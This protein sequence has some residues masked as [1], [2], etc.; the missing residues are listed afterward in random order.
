M[1]NIIT[2][3]EKDVFFEDKPR[4]IPNQEWLL[5]QIASHFE[6]EGEGKKYRMRVRVECE[7][8]K[9]VEL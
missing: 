1:S 8:I 9:E 2:I 7:P 5:M 4:F 3:I 6:T